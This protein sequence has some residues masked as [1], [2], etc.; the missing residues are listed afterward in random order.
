MAD[1]RPRVALD[2][3]TAV[4]VWVLGSGSRGNA[5]LVE[6]SGTRLLVDAGFLPRPLGA[7][8][9]AVGHRPEQVHAVVV[10]HEHEDHAKGAPDGARRFGWQLHASHGTIAAMPALADA[11]AT[12][13]APGASFA[14]GHL[15]VET[16]KVP[17]DA[18]G[19]VAVVVSDPKTG[20]RCGVATDLGTIPA[21]LLTAFR[22]LDILVLESNHDEAM[23]EAGPYPPSV[24][25]RIASRT[26]HLSNR[27][28]ASA[29][30][31]LA[32]KGLRH[33][34]LAHVSEKCNTPALARAATASALADSRFRGT[35]HVAPQDAPIGP[36][37]PVA[38]RVQVARQLELELLG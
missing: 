37:A 18:G 10:T 33:L 1:G 23:L 11:G 24:R 19:P 21:A 34:V 15:V 9:A 31:A 35:L 14:V 2:G 25:A 6:A 29:A 17:H 8:L 4:R 20:A 38:T 30:R 36:F 27:A 16:V 12:G 7:R 3:L 5:L 13:F 32:H 28:A 22:D 26:G